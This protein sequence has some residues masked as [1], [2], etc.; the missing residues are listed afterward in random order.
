M[1]EPVKSSLDARPKKVEVV[2]APKPPSGFV[3]TLLR[4]VS[5]ISIGLGV[6]T[7]IA[8]V[9]LRL[10]HF[11][12]PDFLPWSLKSAVPLI[13]TGVAF[14]ALQFTLQRSRK[15]ILL[16]LMVA[17]AF[18][19]WGLEQFVSDPAVASFID[20]IVV[21]LFVVDLGLVI[22]GHLKPGAPPDRK[23]LPFDGSDA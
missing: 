5:G 1:S 4:L 2:A 3:V 19:L 15:Q 22:Y 14:A 16:G 13:L 21:I 18:T 7:A 12:R 9:V 8:V 20:D 23:E 17:L 10:I 6:C 11:C